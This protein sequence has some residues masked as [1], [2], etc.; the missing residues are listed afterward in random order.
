MNKN[1]SKD[2]YKIKC[3]EESLLKLQ[4]TI[5]KMKK[6][7][8]NIKLSLNAH[9]N[10]QYAEIKVIEENGKWGDYSGTFYMNDKDEENIVLEKA[11]NHFRTFFEDGAFHRNK[12]LGLFLHSPR[13]GKRLIKRMETE[14]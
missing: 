2:E 8:S 3:L 7:V 4:D 9:I 12:K 11:E 6:D 5:N 14:A 13:S 10:R 1:N